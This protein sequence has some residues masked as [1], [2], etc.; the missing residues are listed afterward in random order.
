M[1]TKCKNINTIGHNP[2]ASCGLCVVAC[3]QNA[4]SFDRNANGFYAPAIMSERCADCGICTKVCYKYLQIKEPFENIFKEKSVY[5]AWSKNNETVKTA[6]SGGIGFELT[7]HF[8]DK[9]Y[10]TC[11]CIFDVSNDDCK[12]I[13]AQTCEDLDTI[14]TSKYL[15]S[16]TVE[17]FSQF[18]KD[19]KY[20]VIG[21]PCQIYGLRKYIQIKKWEDNF[22]LVDFFCHGTPSFNLWKKYGEYIK[23]TKKLDRFAAVNFRAKNLESKWHSYAISIRDSSGRKFVQNRAFSEDLFFKFFLNE[24]CLNDSCYQC[25]LRLDHCAADIRIADFW[26]TKYDRN[27]WGVSLVITNTKRGECVFDEI[28]DK[29]VVENCTF[30]DLQNSQGKRFI[31]PNKKRDIV[32]K[33]L[34]S[35][36]SLKKYIR[37]IL[38]SQI[39]IEKQLLAEDSYLLKNEY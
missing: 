39:G 38:H 18:K 17:A 15:Q 6:T 33:E 23:K 34:Q 8:S 13:I 16:S 7:T 5:G 37:K 36:K 4:I 29:L 12:H 26:G 10:K 24:S 25:K 3:P 20:L 1:K 31:M 32:L 14:K 11:G 28:K 9:G 30:Q 27:E 22:I 35:G 19:E 2:C 21:T